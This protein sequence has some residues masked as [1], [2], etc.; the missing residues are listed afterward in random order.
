MPD[1]T[2]SSTIYCMAGLSTIGSIS[3][4]CAFV[5]G[6]NLVPNPAAGMTA[7][8]TFMVIHSWSFL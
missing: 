4:G 2:A 7:F 3:F 6:K 5:A 8:F 1:W